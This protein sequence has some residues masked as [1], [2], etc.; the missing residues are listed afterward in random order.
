MPLLTYAVATVATVKASSSARLM[1][2]RSRTTLWILLGW[3][4]QRWEMP[5]GDVRVGLNAGR[6]T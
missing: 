3:V 4:L 5:A 2:A 6:P 1:H